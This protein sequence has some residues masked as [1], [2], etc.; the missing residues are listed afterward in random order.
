MRPPTEQSK[1]SDSSFKILAEANTINGEPT[2]LSPISDDQKKRSAVWQAV[3]LRHFEAIV[4]PAN[5][6]GGLEW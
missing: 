3:F 1:A 4:N 6:S 5:F 2:M